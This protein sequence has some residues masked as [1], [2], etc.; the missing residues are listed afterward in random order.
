MPPPADDHPSVVHYLD[1]PIPVLATLLLQRFLNEMT[2]I[3]GTTGAV[4]YTKIRS[5]S[6]CVHPHLN[7]PLTPPSGASESTLLL[8]SPCLPRKRLSLT[9]GNQIS[10]LQNIISQ[11]LDLNMYTLNCGRRQDGIPTDGRGKLTGPCSLFAG[12]PVPTLRLLAR[13]PLEYVAW[14]IPHF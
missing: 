14:C 11:R 6:I 10:S 13:L 3:K 9:A 12:V 5:F 7:G 4:S 1:H 8:T 2:W